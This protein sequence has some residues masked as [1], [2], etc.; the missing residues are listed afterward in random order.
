MKVRTGIVFLVA[1]QCRV[2]VFRQCRVKKFRAGM[3]WNFYL[4]V[5]HM[6]A[7]LSATSGQATEETVWI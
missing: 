1:D 5:G 6:E 7:G 4:A 2:A 3:V